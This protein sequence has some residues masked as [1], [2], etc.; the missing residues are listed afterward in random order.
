MKIALVTVYSHTHCT[1]KDVAGG[2]GTVFQIGH[3]S[4]ARILE[5]AKSEL[6]RMASPVLG[7]LA[8]VAEKSGHSVHVVELQRHERS[9]DEV[10]Q[11]FDIAC[12]LTSMVD[13]SAER[14]VMSALHRA[15]THTIAFGAYATAKPE[16]F[17]DAATVVVRGEPEGLGEA[18]FDRS[19]RGVID[20][21]YI[22]DLDALPF[23]SWS[24]FPTSTF[25]YALLTRETTLPVQG[26]RGCAFGC[27][28]CPFRATAPFRQR[29]PENVVAEIAHLKSRYGAR[30]IAFRD[31]LFNLDRDRVKALA[32]GVKPLDVK[33]SAE[34]RADRLDASLLRT[35]RE[36]GLRSLEIG[37]ESVNLD[38]LSDA[39][40]QPPSLREIRDVVK[41]AH[42]LGIRVIAN[43][44]FG[45]PDDTEETI[46]E[47]VAFAK[48]LNTFAVQ[49]TIATPYPGTT[50]T[51]RVQNLLR[52]ERPESYTGWEPTFAH[53]SMSADT[54]RRLREWAYVSYHYRPRYMARFASHALGALF[55]A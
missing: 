25:R 19:K 46:K 27:N 16:F 12:V 33:F 17:L 22:D 41:E 7:Y 3:S 39:K 10:P 6:A 28:Y 8:A 9:R 32:A 37:V 4:R 47:T 30:G 31:P 42:G 2:Y 14:D 24:A 49:F 13:A 34:M 51:T 26:V 36:A 48:E 23:P 29:S 55:D 21:G 53:P 20:A 52:K 40:R 35:L 45:L 15:G 1:L 18:L 44:M 54:L 43:F 11:G 38:M 50:L 5:K